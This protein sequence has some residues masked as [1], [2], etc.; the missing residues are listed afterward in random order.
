MLKAGRQRR[1]PIEPP[2]RSRREAANPDRI[3]CALIRDD[4]LAACST[5]SDGGRIPEGCLGAAR[6]RFRTSARAQRPVEYALAPCT[7]RACRNEKNERVNRSIPT[8]LH[9][10]SDCLPGLSQRL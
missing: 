8:P 3:R 9:E 5:G 10:L 6:D 7:R 4:D 1:A 2:R